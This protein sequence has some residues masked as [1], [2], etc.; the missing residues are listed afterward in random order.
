[1][2][3][4]AQYP[5]ISGVVG[6][7]VTPWLNVVNCQVNFTITPNHTTLARSDQPAVRTPSLVTS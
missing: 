3:K 7:T 5:Q 4:I 6:A 1:M 2:T